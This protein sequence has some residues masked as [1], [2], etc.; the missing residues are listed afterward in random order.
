[1]ATPRKLDVF[2]A[3]F[4]YGG[5][6]ASASEHPDIRGWF[7][8]L[9]V[10]IMRDDRVGRVK[11]QDFNDTP[12]TMTRNDAVATARESGA[13]VLLMID[14][15]QKPDMYLNDPEHPE[16]VPFWDTAFDFLYE[17][18][19]KG[20][21]VIGAPYSGPP[22]VENCYVFR[23]RN[24]ESEHANAD[25]RIGQYTREEAVDM[26]GI[27]ECAALPTGLIMYDMR[28]FD[29]T[30]PKPDTLAEQVTAQFAPRFA[31]GAQSF[32][33][34]DLEN[35]VQQVVAARRER[36]ESWFYYNYTDHLQRKK[37]GTEDV[38]ATRDIAMIGQMELGYNPVHCAWSSWAGHWKPKCV[39]KPQLLTQQ[40]VGEKYRHAA[41][42]GRDKN[43][44][45]IEVAS[46]IADEI[47][48]SRAERLLGNEAS[49]LLDRRERDA[50]PGREHLPHGDGNGQEPVAI[51]AIEAQ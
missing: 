21:V 42:E 50:N 39:G 47:D 44:V 9:L 34:A 46:P 40:D 29:L 23:W 26:S 24:R 10:K 49:R 16:T 31:D 1:M 11:M 18:Y 15:D 3:F 13:D 8:P 19:E 22:P 51:G 4:P 20:P 36:E 35:L 28:V 30:E 12:I 38:L 37:T 14:S 5:N 33:A 32:T 43:F 48:W 6:G 2:F 41:V 7:A 17:H 27:Q 25:Y 45:Q